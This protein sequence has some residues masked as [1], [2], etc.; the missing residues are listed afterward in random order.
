VSETFTFTTE[1]V[2]PWK[3]GGSAVVEAFLDSYL[4]PRSARQGGG[5]GSPQS[6]SF[7]CKMGEEKQ[8][9]NTHACVLAAHP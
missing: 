3:T 6:N 8:R 5:G 2:D 1:L 4:R 7:F 9:S